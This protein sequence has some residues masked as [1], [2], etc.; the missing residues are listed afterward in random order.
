MKRLRHFG[1]ALRLLRQERGLTQKDLARETGLDASQLSRYEGESIEPT[2]GTLQSLLEALDATLS[3]LEDAQRRVALLRS[4]VPS[5]PFPRR[6]GDMVRTGRRG[7]L[8]V[9][10][11]PEI[12][13][14]EDLELFEEAVE[15]VD[16]F[17]HRE[18]VAHRA[19]RRR[20]ERDEEELERQ[21]RGDEDSR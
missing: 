6:R 10:V 19:E 9:D 5:E 4:G 17:L 15:A 7:F 16:R 3:D 13:A 18:A 20:R 8:V 11:S 21:V 1:A 14:G 12:E 2:L